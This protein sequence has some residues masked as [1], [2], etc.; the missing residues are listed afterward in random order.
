MNKNKSII[1]VLVAGLLS[2]ISV[3]AQHG[4]T[5]GGLMTESDMQTYINRLDEFLLTP[6]GLAIFPEVR[7]HDQINAESFHEIA[8][9]TRP[10]TQVNSPLDQFGNVRTCVSYHLPKTRYFT[11]KQSEFNYTLENEPR[12]YKIIL[13]ELFV[14]AGI[15]KPISASIPS[16][17]QISDRILK[18]LFKDEA[19]GWLPGSLP[20]NPITQSGLWCTDQPTLSQFD[21]G[22]ELNTTL[23]FWESSGQVRLV[24][25]SKGRLRT[26]FLGIAPIPKD[27]IQSTLPFNQAG[28]GYKYAPLYSISAT[29]ET[30]VW[31]A[32][33]ENI[34]LRSN[35]M[36]FPSGAQMWAQIL[37]V[38]Y[39]KNSNHTRQVLVSCQSLESW[40]ES[41]L[42]PFI[43]F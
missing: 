30:E 41:P 38:I 11:C 2:G 8:Q 16:E 22:P 43:K 28:I 19:W 32:T 20:K 35:T 29:K 12:I 33:N 10:V 4:A 42:Y 18:H 34:L 39:L 25:W 21:L 17:Y 36:S 1:L 26:L 13:H 9:A 5:G 24:H 40:K 23:L 31:M 15:E 27:C 14:Q 37:S 3:F 7:I 6:E